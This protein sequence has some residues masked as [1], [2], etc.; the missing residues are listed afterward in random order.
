MTKIKLNMNTMEVIFTMS[1][2]NIGAVTCMTEMIK[3]TDWYGGVDGL[4]LILYFDTIG[5]YGSK[6]YML[7][8]DCCDRSLE[9]LELVLR[10]F[11][12]GKLTAQEIIQ[13]VSQR[14]GTPF[15]G[16]KSLTELFK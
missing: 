16:L 3:K 1:E 12:K 13:N 4:M 15:V 10:N 6:I 8:N 2:G 9:K 14:R 7:W 5:I 11:Q